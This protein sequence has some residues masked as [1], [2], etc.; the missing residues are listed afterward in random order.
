[1]LSPLSA[2]IG[3]SV[4]SLNDKW[5]AILRNSR[6]LSCRH[7]AKC[8]IR[9]PDPCGLDR[10]PSHAEI[11]VGGRRQGERG[12]FVEPTVVT[13]LKQQDEMIQEEIFGPVITV[14]RFS[15]EIGRAHV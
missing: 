6:Q 10:K 1:M 2:E 15:D 11:V 5:P 8:G 4:V 12:F 3:M 14:Q 7:R 9:R 13:G